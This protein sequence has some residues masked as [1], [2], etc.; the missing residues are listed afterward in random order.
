MIKKFIS[1]QSVKNILFNSGWLLVDKSVRLLFGLLISAWVARFLGAEDYGVLAYI[2][3][4][5]T[6]FQVIVKLGLDGVVV[7]ELSINKEHNVII[8]TAFKLRLFIGFICWILVFLYLIIFNSIDN[9]IIFLVSG[10]ALIFQP[11]ETIDLLYQSQ[12]RSKK[13]VRVKI[14]AY[15]VVNAIKVVLIKF[16][17]SLYYFTAMITFESC[18]VGLGL[19]ISY[20][21]DKNKNNYDKLKYDHSLAKRLILESWPFMLSTLSVL[22][23]MRVDII[24]LNELLGVK[25]LGIYTGVLIFSTIWQFIPT[26]LLISMN[27]MV[28]KAKR[29]SQDNYY[30]IIK[31]SFFLFSILGWSISILMFILSPYIVKVFL[32][33]EYIDGIDALSIHVLSNLFMGLGVAQNLWILNEKKGKISLYRSLFGLMVCVVLNYSLI[34]VWGIQG[35]A[36]TAV[37]TQFMSSILI[38]AILAPKVFKIQMKA[39]MIIPIFFDFINDFKVS[40]GHV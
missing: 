7:R 15:C 33:H 30:K 34:P 12:N 4:F 21:L 6:L 9:A 14:F 35:A 13:T 10:S 8:G 29:K 32:G 28:A 19:I 31:Y 39:L 5:I 1:N 38:N 37:L 3:T 2:L 16:D 40:K 25:Q 11:I 36:I 23:Y 20:R 26:T 24:I 18:I 27:P 17:A 22:L